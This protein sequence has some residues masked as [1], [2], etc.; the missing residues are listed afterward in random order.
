MDPKLRAIIE[1]VKVDVITPTQEED[2]KIQLREVS[3]SFVSEF[4]SCPSHALSNRDKPIQLQVG[5]SQ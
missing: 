3:R 1:Q 4:I 2:N 5:K